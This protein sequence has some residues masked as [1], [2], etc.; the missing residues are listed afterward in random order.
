MKYQYSIIIPHFNIPNLLR[1]CLWSIP[2][3]DDTQI[4][5]VDDKS[6]EENMLILKKV[7]SDFPYVTFIYSEKNGGGGLARNIGLKY[8]AGRYILF[9]D[10]DD[11]FNYCIRDFLD[12]YY[13]ESYDLVFFNANSLVSNSYMQ[14]NRCS[15]L[16]WMISNY[17][18]KNDASDLKYQFGEPWCKMVRKEIIDNNN[19]FFEETSIHNDTRFS[20]LVGYYSQS[21]KVDTRAVYCITEREGSVS[22]DISPQKLFVRTRV[23]AE[24]NIF[25]KKNKIPIFDEHMLSPLR[26]FICDANMSNVKKYFK[27]TSDAGLTYG[28]V[29]TMIFKDLVGTMKRTSYR[30]VMSFLHSL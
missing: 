23:F 17:Y 3:R 5:V 22:V 26:I 8:A 18:K 10:A 28:D 24:K 4:I 13:A 9:A 20:Y 16:N 11:F 6:S 19:I 30:I 2:K 12:D 1:R 25:L 15:N 29:M 21:I 7:E 14:C 27:M